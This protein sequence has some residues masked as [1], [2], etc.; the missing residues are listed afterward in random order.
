M[1]WYPVQYSYTRENNPVYGSGYRQVTYYI[2]PFQWYSS[3][4]S[5]WYIVPGGSFNYKDSSGASRQVQATGAKGEGSFQSYVKFQVAL[6]GYSYYGVS[7]ESGLGTATV[8]T[9]FEIFGAR[10]YTRP[11]YYAYTAA[12]Y[13]YTAEKKYQQLHYQYYVV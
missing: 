5:S 10:K 4:G 13:A 3:S 2:F 9:Y 11:A 12:V 7:K 6:N 1:S 8:H